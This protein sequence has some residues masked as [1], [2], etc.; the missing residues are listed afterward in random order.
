MMGAAARITASGLLVAGASAA[1]AGAA[2]A[3]G[4]ER[5]RDFGYF[6][7]DL[8]V[9]RDSVRVPR[10]FTLDP[11]SVAQGPL[12]E[13]LE[14]RDAAWD[15]RETGDGRLYRFRYVYQVFRVPAELE[16][17]QVPDRTLV[18]G[19]GSDGPP[20]ARLLRGFELSL[21]PL[22]DSTDA[23]APDWPVPTPSGSRIRLRA[24]SL[25]LL[26][27]AWGAWGAWAAVER[28]RR[29][30]RIFGQANRRVRG[31]QDCGE[32]MRVLHRALEARAGRALFA[33]DLDLFV[34]R[35]PPAADARQ[36]LGRFF[37]MSDAIFYGED[38]IEPGGDCLG[39]VRALAQRLADLERRRGD[40]H[41]GGE[42]GRGSGRGS[43]AWSS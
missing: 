27:G 11:A 19:S 24:A 39:R 17:L 33:H 8:V 28:R 12:P 2:P 40:G 21:S 20:E 25:V 31:A 14:L 16:R 15:V 7:G 32:A 3:Q 13:W 9:Q 42:S 4:V 22:T 1:A 5:P 23:A 41:G 6:T 36:E 37:V 30:R 35:W 10:G 43:G 18:F 29:G 26:A 38:S 34:E